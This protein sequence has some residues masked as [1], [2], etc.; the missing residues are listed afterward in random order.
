MARIKIELID[1]QCKNTE[2]VSGGDE[3]YLV[4]AMVGGTE[5]KA[6]LTKPIRINNNQT[7]KI[8]SDQS[9]MFEGD[10]PEGETIKGAIAAY[11]EDSNHDWDKYGKI[12]TTIT[13][14]VSSIV[15]KAGGPKGV[16]AGT[17]L[18]ATVG[19]L[20]Q[21]MSLDKDDNLGSVQLVISSAGPE[22][23]EMTICFSGNLIPWYSDWEYRL[24]YKITRKF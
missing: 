21:I 16:V 2:D 7:K 19:V 3:I 6:F 4:G 22:L 23:E 10:L 11:D 1:V 14:V 24:R 13:N 15:S 17:I 9:V 18:S 5:T 12:V 20:G 8:P